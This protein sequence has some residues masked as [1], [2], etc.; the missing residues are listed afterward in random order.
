MLDGCPVGVSFHAIQVMSRR[1]RMLPSLSQEMTA[2]TVKS[3][4]GPY[5]Y[6]LLEAN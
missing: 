3:R 6:G 1:G 2:E 5:S 4:N